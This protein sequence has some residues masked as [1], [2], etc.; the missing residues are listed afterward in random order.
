M[1]LPVLDQR[2][3]KGETFG[4]LLAGKGMLV[5]NLKRLYLEKRLPVLDQ[6]VRKGETVRNIKL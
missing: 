2:V 5:R 6:R 4:A 3:G 1:R